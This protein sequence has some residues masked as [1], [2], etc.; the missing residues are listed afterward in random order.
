MAG[1][2]DSTRGSLPLEG[3]DLP[4]S[5]VIK[6]VATAAP[7]APGAL[8]RELLALGAR[9]WADR[10]YG[11]MLAD[12]RAATCD[13][14]TGISNELIGEIVDAVWGA[15]GDLS[16]VIDLLE[17]W[18][19]LRASASGR[20]ERMRFEASHPVCQ[21]ADGGEPD[22]CEAERCVRCFGKRSGFDLAD[23]S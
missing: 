3:V 18:G 5:T 16:D 19:R 21:C 20:V 10:R 1:K 6:A 12:G 4:P 23:A 13:A 11:P 15:G 8:G 7:G 2:R 9:E 17:T 14:A 22:E